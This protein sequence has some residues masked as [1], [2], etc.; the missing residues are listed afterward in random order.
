MEPGFGFCAKFA[1][2]IRSPFSFWSTKI[3]FRRPGWG[4]TAGVLP[5]PS[6]IRASG[7]GGTIAGA[8]QCTRVRPGPIQCIT[9]ALSRTPY[10]KSPMQ[11]RHPVDNAHLGRSLS[12]S[13]CCGTPMPGTS[14]NGCVTLVSLQSELGSHCLFWS[15]WISVSVSLFALFVLVCLG[16]PLFAYAVIPSTA[17]AIGGSR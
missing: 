13:L 8:P 6:G 9:E 7:V 14:P 17:L 5:V 11:G 10:R 3:R 16:L 12:L 4:T 1:A 15:A 2:E